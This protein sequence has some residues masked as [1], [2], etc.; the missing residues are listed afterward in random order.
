[1]ALDGAGSHCLR[2]VTVCN[3]QCGAVQ[4]V[5][6][7]GCQDPMPEAIYACDVLALPAPLESIV[8]S[9]DRRRC[10][11]RYCR[12]S[13][14][15]GDQYDCGGHVAE[16][17]V[18]SGFHGCLP[19][20]FVIIEAFTLQFPTL[21]SFETSLPIRF[22]CRLKRTHRSGS[23]VPAAGLPS[24]APCIMVDND[25]GSRRTYPERAATG[26]GRAW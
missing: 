18:T 16:W 24:P 19:S 10:H 26:G 23:S 13:Q 22:R 3:D 17:A 25:G 8:R 9:A 5:V 12:Q 6:S 11:N 1:M 15:D 7:A 14:E 20:V 21:I 4:R 2:A